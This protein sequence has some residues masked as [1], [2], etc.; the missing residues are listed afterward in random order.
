MTV[1][2]YKILLE[3]IEILETI[4]EE[5]VKADYVKSPICFSLYKTWKHFDDQQWKPPKNNKRK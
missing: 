2:E 4:Y 1:E 3:A 5:A